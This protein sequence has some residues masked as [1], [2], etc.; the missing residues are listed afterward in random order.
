MLP[1]VTQVYHLLVFVD[2]NDPCTLKCFSKFIPS[3]L[4]AWLCRELAFG[5]AFLSCKVG[6]QS[7]FHNGSAK[8]GFNYHWMKSTYLS[9]SQK[10]EVFAVY[11]A[12]NSN[13]HPVCCDKDALREWHLSHEIRLNLKIIKFYLKRKTLLAY[14][15]IKWYI[16]G[17]LI[18]LQPFFDGLLLMVQISILHLL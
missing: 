4:K 5:L 10:R 1:M 8:N 18:F 13:V 14:K 9:T 17:K 2:L 11:S 6:H 3:L 12:L 16:K 15:M 7:S